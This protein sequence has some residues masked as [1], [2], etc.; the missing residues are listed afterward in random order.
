VPVPVL[1]DEKVI[2]ARKDVNNL[3]AME[4]MLPIVVQGRT[5]NY[6]NVKVITGYNIFWIWD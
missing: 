1:N 5:I 4:E 6:Y 3:L 2:F